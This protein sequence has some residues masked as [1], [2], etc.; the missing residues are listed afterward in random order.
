MSA[1]T[2]RTAFILGAGLGMRLRPL[3]EGCPKPLLPVGGRP[4]ITYAM[5][6]CLTAGV[7]RFIVNTHHCPT[8]FDRVFPEKRWRGRPIFLSHEPVLLD[9]AGGMKNIEGLLTEEDEILLVYNGD[10]LADL[11]LG[12]LLEIHAA[13]GKEVTLVLRSDGPQKNVALD[14]EGAV[15]DLRGVLGNPGVRRCQFT[16]IYAVEKSFFRRLTLGKVESVIPV[17]A[18]MIRGT[19]GSVGNVVVD[20][21]VWRDIGDP[22]VYHQVNATVP[23]LSYFIDRGGA[24][25]AVAGSGGGWDGEAAAFVRKTI[26]LPKDIAPD[27]VPVGRGGSDRDYFR[28][29]AAGRDPLILMRYGRL[30]E[31]NT[32]YAAIAVFLRGIGVAVPEILGHD[33]ERGLLLMEDLGDEDLFA[34]RNAPWDFRRL[35]YEKALTMISRLHAYPPSGVPSAGI[36]LMPGFSPELY[37]WERDYFREECVTKTCGICLTDRESHA[38]E[39][40][41]D[42]LARSLLKM[43]QVLVHRDLQSQNVMVRKGAP[44]LID[45][46]G[47]RLGSLFYD[48]GSLL[49]DPYVE[50]RDEERTVLLR[51]YYD[52]SRPAQNWD[53]FEALFHLASVQRLMQ[54]LGA[55]GF[56]GRQRGTSHFF[57]H[58]A[59]AL[60]RLIAVTG[61]MG[62]L[63]RLHDLARRCRAF[64]TNRNAFNPNKG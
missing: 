48:L 16:G 61:R 62:T 4:L 20:E 21:G 27:L 26:G 60:E 42:A 55:Y 39:T 2:I 29:T 17:L 38:L 50:F 32:A 25:P 34:Y 45:F 11:P 31:E 18:E 24:P 3:T 13:G 10:I 1:S 9:T 52:L 54:A 63:P 15:C 43:P 58:I 14:E 51:T 8:A 41:L 30:R 12:R 57:I 46:Q 19:P 47:M 23:K 35:L 28:V 5:D 40:E 64:L 7:E 49:H 37:R 56:L 53:E 44:V 59:P 36:R 22:E 33:P 6:H